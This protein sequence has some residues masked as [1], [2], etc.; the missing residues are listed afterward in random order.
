MHAALYSGEDTAQT[1]GWLSPLTLWRN[2]KPKG[3]AWSN[4]TF[5]LS[6]AVLKCNIYSF[7]RFI[8]S[9]AAQI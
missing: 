3:K 9:T 6:D 2:K 5:L 4:I 1:S 7:I 8:Q